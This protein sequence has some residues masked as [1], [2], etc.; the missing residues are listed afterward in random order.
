MLR[1]SVRELVWLQ[2]GARQGDQ[3][4][5]KVVATRIENRG[6]IGAHQRERN[7]IGGARSAAEVRRA[8]SS[9]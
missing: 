8:I 3:A 5:R 9:A 1:V 2:I 6:K 4:M 7:L